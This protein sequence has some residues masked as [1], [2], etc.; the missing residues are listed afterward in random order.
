LAKSCVEVMNKNKMLCG[1]YDLENNQ[2]LPFER[3]RYYVGKLLTTADFLAEQTYFNNKRRFLSSLMFGAGIICG[4]EVNNLDD[5]SIMVDSGVAIDGLGREIVLE[6]SVVK[7]LSAIDGFKSICSESATLCLRYREEPVHPVY[8]VSRQGASEEYE[9]NRIREGWQLFLTDTELLEAAPVM[10]SEFLSSARL[11]EDADFAVDISVPATVSC[12]S[13]AKLTLC[14][15]KLSSADKSFSLDCVLQTPAFTCKSG[16]HELLLHLSDV[17]PEQGKSVSREYWLTA[18]AQAVADSIIIAKPSFTKIAVG[19]AEKRLEDSIILKVAVAAIPVSELIAREIG[20]TNLEL[21]NLAGSVDYIRLANLSIQHTKN[22]YIIDKVTEDGVK[23]YL[24]TTATED[25]R[26]EYASYFDG[27]GAAPTGGAAQSD[28]SSAQGNAAYPEAQYATGICEIPLKDKTHKGELVY[29]DEVMHGLGKGNVYVTVGFEYLT[30]DLRQKSTE[31][32]TIYGDPE[33]FAGEEPPISLARTS[34]KVMN[35]RGS[36][37]VA[38]QL[39]KE[40]AYVLLV[41]RWVAIKLPSADDQSIQ[42]R[43]AGKSISAV[44]PTAVLATRESHFFNVRFKNMEPCALTYSLMEKDSGEIKSDGIYTAPAKEGVFEI[45]ISCSDMPI[46]CTYA[47][48]IV[49]KK[50][51]GSEDE[52]NQIQEKV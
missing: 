30:D 47:Y 20:K 24:H 39:L 48:A 45:L 15:T 11:Y 38:A 51:A 40:S 19:K 37:V 8:S 18:Q 1:V 35:D 4:L 36:F 43:I 49:K 21:K 33:L 46:I 22:A 13:S 6:N 34:V 50:E 10:E 44:P 12:N 31:K 17:L 7:K 42:Q 16:D 25:L 23:R 28:E 27:D 52:E 3:N 2:L 14:I 32:R 9:L 5:L 41:L 26:R 29:S